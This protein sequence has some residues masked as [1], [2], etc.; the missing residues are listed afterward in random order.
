LFARYL[1]R[2]G[3]HQLWPRLESGQLSLTDKTF[4]DMS[5]IYPVLSDLHELRQTLGK[6]RLLDLDIGP[7]GRNRL[8]FA[9]FRT[10][11]SRN[12]PSNSRFIFGAAKW[13]RNMILAPKGYGIS[14]D[15]W[16]AQEVAVA[17]ALSGDNA[18]W[19]AA[20]TGD[21]YIAFGKA[22]GRLPDDATKDS[23]EE[24]RALFKVCTL[25]PLYGQSAFGLARRVGITE[26]EAEGLLARHRRLYPRFWEWTRYNSDLAMMGYALTTRNGWTLEYAVGSFADASPR[27]A[28]NFPVQ[29]NAAEIMRL[30]GIWGVEAG[31]K[32]CA[33]VHDAFLIEA[34]ADEI[35][36]ASATFRRP[37]PCAGRNR[38]SKSEASSC[39]KSW[40]RKW[41]RSK[42]RKATT[43]GDADDRQRGRLRK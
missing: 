40:S 24:A 38:T 29:A 4:S 7:D 33:P 36:D 16:I 1:E 11:T 17:G 12:A 35:E 30:A 5:K 27:T 42:R 34:P 10:K 8:Y 21:P 3:L 39:T 28:M 19:E 25:A 41:R 2:V 23:H 6:L 43:A 32:L 15:D 37:R 18:L 26:S 13:I 9:P 14:Y 22:I 20:A 31:I